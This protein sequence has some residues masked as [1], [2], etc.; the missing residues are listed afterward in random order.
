MAVVKHNS[1]FDITATDDAGVFRLLPQDSV[2]RHTVDI[3]GG[4]LDYTAVAGTFVLFDQ[5]GR[6]SAVIFYTAYLADGADPSRRPLTFAFNGGPGAASAFLNLGLVGP[7]LV[8]FGADNCDGSVVRLFDNPNTWLA[9][10]DLVLIDPVG[11]GWSRPARPDGGGFWGVAADAESLATAIARYLTKNRRA[12][13]PKYI[14]GESYGGFRAAK[15]AQ[16]LRRDQGHMIS[17]IVMVSPFLDSTGVLYDHHFAL[18]AALRLPSLVAAELERRAAF[19]E[20]KLAEA[21]HF[22][23]TEYLPALAGPPLQG[24]AARIFYTRVGQMTGLP[25]AIVARSQGFIGDTYIKNLR[26]AEGKI[27]SPF[28]LNFAADDPFPEQRYPGDD[29][30]LVEGVIRAYGG[31]FSEY[32]QND[33]NFKTDLTYLLFSREIG[34]KWN[35]RDGAGRMGSSVS[36]DLRTLLALSSS[37]RLLIGHGLSDL[38]IPYGVSQYVLNHIPQIGAA[39]RIQFRRYHGGH[40]FY[41]N[42]ESRRAFSADAKMLYETSNGLA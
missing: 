8:E 27:V 25:E 28:D 17:G 7:K 6:R 19:S 16:V 33:L 29:D 9:F 41:R 18:G 14:L 35:W 39:G 23:L 5:P 15:V 32:A 26:A 12:G 34:R 2:T 4:R 31:A 40:M 37:F 3:A 13:S 30:P 36:A 11:T 21:E 10:T 22:A 38:K 24:E 20:Q 42:P 1:K